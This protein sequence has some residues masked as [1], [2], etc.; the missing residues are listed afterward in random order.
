MYRT[1]V[2]HSRCSQSLDLRDGSSG[3]EVIFHVQVM[4]SQKVILPWD[5]KVDAACLSERGRKGLL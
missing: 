3:S 4:P 2:G 5:E 1:T